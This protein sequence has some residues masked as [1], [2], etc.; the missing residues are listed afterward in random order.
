MPSKPLPLHFNDEDFEFS[1]GG[2]FTGD[3]DVESVALH[4]VGHIIGLDHSTLPSAVMYP[5]MS[6]KRALTADDIAGVQSFYP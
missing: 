4:E 5:V 2:V 1:T 3:E 6:F